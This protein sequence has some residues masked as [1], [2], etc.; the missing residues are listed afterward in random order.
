M[1]ASFVAAWGVFAVGD[2]LHGRC[3]GILLTVL[4]AALPVGLVQWMGYTESLFT[5]FAAWALYAVLTDR[6][7]TAAWL[8]SWPV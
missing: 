3:V 6:P 8:A 1:V 7:L 4:W 5:A 2:R